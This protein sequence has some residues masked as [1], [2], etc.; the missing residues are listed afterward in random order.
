M[1]GSGSEGMLETLCL[2]AINKHPIYNC[3]DKYLQCISEISNIKKPRNIYKAKIHTFLA[4]QEEYIP[5]VGI[6]AKKKLFDFNL[7]CFSELVEFIN[8]I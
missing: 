8:A 1:P 3:V 4:G 6:A 5:S 2:K 7:K